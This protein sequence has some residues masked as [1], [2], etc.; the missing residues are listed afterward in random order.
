V[1]SYLDGTGDSRAGFDERLAVLGAMNMMR[2][3]GIFARLVVRDSKPRYDQF[4]PRLRRLL[5]E[6]LAHPAMSEMQDFVR[7]VAP[8]LL[9]A[10]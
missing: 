4:Q 2:I 9:A 5:N 10:A 8:H 6:T 1:R 3:M 7:A